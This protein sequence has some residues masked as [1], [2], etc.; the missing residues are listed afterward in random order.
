MHR[1]LRH[2]IL[3]VLLSGLFGGGGVAFA[4]DPPAAEQG[5]QSYTGT[6]D[7][8]DFRVEVPQ[9]WNGTLVLYSHGY[10]PPGFP[11]FGGISLTNRFLGTE[12]QN[13]LLDHGYALAASQFQDHGVGYQ[14]ANGMND[15]MALLD[16]FDAH[17]GH[18]LHTVASGQSLGSSI[19]VLLAEAHPDRFDGVAT[20]CAA[21]DGNATF[22]AALDM[23]FAIKTLLAP[24][25]D[26]ELVRAAD[27]ARSTDLLVAAI[28]QALTTPQGRA[29][30][31]LT[32]A[33][34]NVAG[35]YF[36]H[37]PQPT[38]PTERIRQQAMWIE[39]AYVKSFGPSG[40]VDLERKAGGNPSWNVGIDYRRQL[41]RSS[42]REL[43]RAAYRAAGLDLGR[44]LARLAVA[45]R[46]APDPGAV[47]FMDR[48]V[49][50]GSA[51]A[52][53]ITLHSTGD[54]GAV[55]DQERWLAGQID[56]NGD[57][58]QLRQLYVDRGQHCT[59]SSAEEI[60]Q[61]RT[62][63]AR[64]DTGRWPDTSPEALREQAAALGDGYQLVFDL[65]TFSDAPMAP[66]FTRF[67]PPALLRPSRQ[68]AVE[69]TVT[70]ALATK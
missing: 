37:E 63:F 69:R 31:A 18:P 49:P 1:S 8:A 35:W 12:T 11:V 20:M 50:R 32:G 46:I 26:I 70:A 53:I 3:V 34:N 33:L 54:G 59:Y 23:T 22:N 17:V 39:N 47:A 61:L 68:G 43:V 40:R 52:P 64:I 29:R 44:D 28:E 14:V 19:A 60:T 36:G 6:I 66:A 51:A 62:L 9:H 16:W 2:L 58:H 65:A 45:P 48:Y 10:L 38:D 57:P 27:P 25:E 15:Q 30:L 67:E 5:R 21:D 41:A 56:R 55:P 4:A 7:G 24:G 13:W 42:Q